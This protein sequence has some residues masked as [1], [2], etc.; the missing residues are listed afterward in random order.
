MARP[1]CCP[2]TTLVWFL[3]PNEMPNIFKGWINDRV[4]DATSLWSALIHND[5]MSSWRYAWKGRLNWRIMRLRLIYRWTVTRTTF[6]WIV[7]KNIITS[8][9][10][11]IRM[12][13]TSKDLASLF[14]N[15]ANILFEDAPNNCITG[16][17]KC[18]LQSHSNQSSRTWAGRRPSF[19][20]IHRYR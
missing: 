12:W 13:V 5:K 1:D 11:T 20:H 10:S 4:L 15:M 17:G 14:E 6:S 9:L 2:E 18:H 3:V 19:S 16:P 7:S 8:N